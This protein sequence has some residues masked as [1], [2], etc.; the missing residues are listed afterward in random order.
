MFV[1]KA[2]RLFGSVG[3]HSLAFV[4][5]G[6]IDR[7]R[8]FFPNG[9]VS[10]DLLA[11]GLH[12]RMGAQESVGQGLVF[13][14][15]S[16]QEML[17]LNIR[18]PELAGFVAREKDDA[19]G[20]LRI[21]FKHKT[22]PRVLETPDRLPPTRIPPRTLWP[23]LHYA[24]RVPTIPIPKWCHGSI[25]LL[26]VPTSSRLSSSCELANSCNLPFPSLDPTKVIRA[27]LRR[28]RLRRYLLNPSLMQP[29]YAMTAARK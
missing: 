21:T 2:L 8:Y 9:G 22:L 24:I 3:K 12:R 4:A 19:P 18:R 11:D 26:T 17:R 15:Q 10:L 6:Q 1:G 27:R 25:R 13:A 16:Q 29:Q 7:G 20:F 14:K 23:L 28:Q 5:Q